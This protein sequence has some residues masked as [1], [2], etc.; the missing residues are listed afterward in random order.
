ME[1]DTAE[2]DG[3]ANQNPELVA[4]AERLMDKARVENEN[5]PWVPKR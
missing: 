5:F 3:V 4:K 2:S 1:S